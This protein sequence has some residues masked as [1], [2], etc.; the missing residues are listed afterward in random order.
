M[1]WTDVRMIAENLYDMNPDLDPTT[2]RFT[3]MHKWICEMEDFDDDPE[4]SNE[5]ILEAILTIWLEE[6]E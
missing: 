3:D 5:Q 1:K 6:Y 4:A 2:V